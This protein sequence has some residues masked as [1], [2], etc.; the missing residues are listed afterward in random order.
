MP[1]GRMGALDPP[2][3]AEACT[4]WISLS[5]LLSM[6]CSWHSQ[7]HCPIQDPRMSPFFPPSWS[8]SWSDSSSYLIPLPD[9][10]WSNLKPVALVGVVRRLFR[11]TNPL[12][13]WQAMG[14]GWVQVCGLSGTHCAKVCPFSAVP[15]Y[16]YP[17]FPLRSYRIKHHW[18]SLDI[19]EYSISQLQ[20]IHCSQYCMKYGIFT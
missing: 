5:G 7:D 1:Q 12:L 3:W 16:R 19:T 4:L 17:P 20:T 6:L 15:S 10:I 9:G 18:E 14:W 8:V 2:F 11:Y 13:G